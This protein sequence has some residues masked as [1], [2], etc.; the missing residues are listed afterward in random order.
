MILWPLYVKHDW[1]AS[2]VIPICLHCVTAVPILQLPSNILLAANSSVYV[3]HVGRVSVP[4]LLDGITALT[5]YS[6][7]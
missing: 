7:R 1:N 2:R 4:S 3:L 6:V 5:N